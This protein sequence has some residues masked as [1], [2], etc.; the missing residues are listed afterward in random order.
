MVV[1]A[2][3]LTVCRCLKG[4]RRSE[5]EQRRKKS[6]SNSSETKRGA[7]PRNAAPRSVDDA[8]WLKS[9]SPTC[10]SSLTFDLVSWAPTC[11]FRSFSTANMG[12]LTYSAG[13][14]TSA[15][16]VV[17]LCESAQE[18]PHLGRAQLR[19]HD[20]STIHREWRSFQRMRRRIQ[21]LNAR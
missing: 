8:E 12:A 2:T 17:G 10:N 5:V 1:A 4:W 13:G 20:R 19:K 15:L 11:S 16:T 14:A 7:V 21:S 9:L 6:R 3:S 18:G